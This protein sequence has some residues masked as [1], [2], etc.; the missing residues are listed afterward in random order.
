MKSQLLGDERG[1]V[2]VEY[3]TVLFVIALVAGSALV[4]LGPALVELFSQATALLVL[5]T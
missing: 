5:P 2:A 4:L 3:L 1:S